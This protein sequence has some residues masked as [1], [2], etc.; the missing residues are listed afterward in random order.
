[1]IKYPCPSCG[2]K[3]ETDD[4][5][6]GKEESCPTCGQVNAVPLSKQDLTENKRR[7]QEKLR[8]EN[9]VSKAEVQDNQQ[10]SQQRQAAQVPQPVV[11][12]KPPQAT[13]EQLLAEQGV[14]TCQHCHGSMVKTTVYSAGILSRLLAGLVFLV[15]LALIV[16]SLAGSILTLN[17]SIVGVLVMIMALIMEGKR[18]KV[19]K[20]TSCDCIL[21]RA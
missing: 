7:Q 5:L 19:W 3:L 15:G 12:G 18:R 2:A 13:A 16:V 17:L 20:C 4:S 10:N 9:P 11:Q 6:S 1:M 14:L 8:E 21:D